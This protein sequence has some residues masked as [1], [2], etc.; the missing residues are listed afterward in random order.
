MIMIY[1]PEIEEIINSVIDNSYC[2]EYDRIELFD[3]VESMPRY[4]QSIL[5]DSLVDSNIKDARQ[6]K[7]M[8]HDLMNTFQM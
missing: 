5:R 8:I 6:L 3:I 7:E 4:M 2:T 1:Y